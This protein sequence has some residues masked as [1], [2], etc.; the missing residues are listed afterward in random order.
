MD[1][2]AVVESRKTLWRLCEQIAEGSRPAEPSV[3]AELSRRIRGARSWSELFRLLELRRRYRDAEEAQLRR[4]TPEQ[5][6]LRYRR[7]QLTAYQ[8]DCWE[9][10]FPRE[11]PR[12]NGV[13]EWRARRIFDI[14]DGPKR[15]R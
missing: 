15:N 3:H 14:V 13:P 11:I 8:G 5:R 6:M 10:L 1:A 7:G 12:V 2:E 9:L 4:L